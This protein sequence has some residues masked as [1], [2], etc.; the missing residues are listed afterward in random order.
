MECLDGIQ[1]EKRKVNKNKGHLNKVW[2]LAHNNISV[3]VH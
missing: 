2:T 3:L 1:E